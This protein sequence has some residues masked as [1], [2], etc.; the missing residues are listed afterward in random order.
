M[1]IPH[2][3]LT[4]NF[5]T[6]KI[7]GSF[8]PQGWSFFTRNPREKVYDAFYL[9]A[10]Q[11]VS[12]FT[13]AMSPTNYFGASRSQRIK[14]SELMQLVNQVPDSCWIDSSTEM[15]KAVKNRFRLVTLKNK[16]SY[17]SLKGEYYLTTQEQIPWAWIVTVTSKN[18]S[19]HYKMAK[20]LIQ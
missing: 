16:I 19:P 20:A 9:E 11:M 17:P 18:I 2:S 13:P 12:V 15:S 8:L 6:N 5:S 7:I 10:G 3:P 14:F 4:F 1:I